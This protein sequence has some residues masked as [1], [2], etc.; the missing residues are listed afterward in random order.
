MNSSLAYC[1]NILD[2]K[3]RATSNIFDDGIIIFQSKN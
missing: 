1:F 2:F 3:W